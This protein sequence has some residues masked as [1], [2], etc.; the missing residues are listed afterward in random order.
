MPAPKMT[1]DGLE[2]NQPDYNYT[3]TIDTG[4][5]WTLVCDNW[6]GS[7]VKSPIITSEFSIYADKATQILLNNKAKL[8]GI[9]DS[10]LALAENSGFYP[11]SPVFADS[12]D[13][14]V[15]LLEPLE[16]SNLLGSPWHLIENNFK[17]INREISDSYKI[18]VYANK[19][20]PAEGNIVLSRYTNIINGITD[21][22]TPPK[23]TLPDNML[24]TQISKGGYAYSLDFKR[25]NYRLGGIYS[26]LNFK[27]SL[28]LTK[29]ILLFILDAGVNTFDIY[30]PDR[31]LIFGEEVTGSFDYDV[32]DY[33]RWT[34]KCINDQIAVTHEARDYFAFSL[35]LAPVIG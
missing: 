35:K 2:L 24:N 5:Y 9:A 15:R 1:L 23:I 21:L 7:I 32:S 20:L 8:G 6:Q 13:F 4:I 33:T 26:E 10:Q 29:Q 11:F 18:P 27:C 30:I 28:Q 14:Y 12:S 25:E 19:T 3:S 22:Y 34:V 16:Y 17:L 31:Y